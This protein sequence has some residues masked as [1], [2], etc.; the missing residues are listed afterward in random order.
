VIRAKTLMREA[1]LAGGKPILEFFE[2]L[3]S[4]FEFG[5]VQIQDKA[6]KRRFH[7]DVKPRLEGRIPREG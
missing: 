4:D 6:Q 2:T 7:R 5:F 1:A 3:E